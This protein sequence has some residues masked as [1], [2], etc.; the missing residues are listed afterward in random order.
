MKKIVITSF[1]CLFSVMKNDASS[2]YQ[3]IRIFNG[4]YQSKSGIWDEN[5]DIGNITIAAE[6]NG[7]SFEGYAYAAGGNL[8]VH[9]TSSN[10]YDYYFGNIA[11]GTLGT[12]DR[13]WR[14]E[15]LDEGVAYID[16]N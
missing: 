14:L 5:L 9:A 13:H 16:L 4:S 8:S 10:T 11:Q 7:A 2:F 15:V 1:L 6:Y 3:E 12:S